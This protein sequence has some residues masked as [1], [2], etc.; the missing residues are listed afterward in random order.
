MMKIKNTVLLCCSFMFVGCI[1]MDSDDRDL[2]HHIA[3]IGGQIDKKVLGINENAW[4][5]PIIG[6]Y[7]SFCKSFSFFNDPQQARR[8]L[9]AVETVIQE[10]SDHTYSPKLFEALHTKHWHFAYLVNA[11]VNDGIQQLRQAD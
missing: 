7:T 2:N 8:E 5:T 9:S 6:S 11:L 1:A 3:V 4:H 10:A